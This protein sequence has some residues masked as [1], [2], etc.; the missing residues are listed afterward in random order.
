M[1]IYEPLE[2]DI[3]KSILDY[4]HAKKVFC[5]KQANTGIYKPDGSGYIPIGLKGVSDILGCY[6][7]RFL[8]IE[9]KRPSGK[10]SPDQE[11]FLNHVREN[12]GIALV[13]RSIDDIINIIS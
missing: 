2:K 12:G 3:Q 9:V 8:A 5:W 11:L 10:L 6:K 1:K 4:L 7:G 13:A